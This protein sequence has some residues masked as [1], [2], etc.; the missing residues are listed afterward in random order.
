MIQLLMSTAAALREIRRYQKSTDLLMAK[1]P[2]ARLVRESMA[3]ASGSVTRIQRVALEALQEAAEAF[4][5]SW[6]EDVNLCAIHAKRVTIMAKDAQLL[7]TLRSHC[8][9]MNDLER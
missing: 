7:K 4:I 9:G 6:F 8:A 3:D 2:F 5:V 1:A